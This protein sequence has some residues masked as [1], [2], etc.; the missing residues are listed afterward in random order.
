MK[1]VTPHKIARKKKS[2][3]SFLPDEKE[4]LPKDCPPDILKRR[5]LFLSAFILLLC[6]LSC[7]T[8]FLRC[9]QP[10][11]GLTACIYQDGQL[12]LTIDLHTVT[13]PYTV[14]IPAPEGGSNLIEVRPDAIGII[15]ADCPDK[16]CVLTGFADSTLLPIVCLP[17][18]LVIQLSAAG[19]TA[20]DGISY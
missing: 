9:R 20:P 13:Q 4:T 12:I 11:A 3:R 17:H 10:S 5:G 7:L 15:D 19:Q 16:L 8:I 2:R 18:K 1:Q 14:P 6:L